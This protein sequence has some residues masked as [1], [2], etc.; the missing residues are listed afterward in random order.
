MTLVRW[1]V[2]LLILSACSSAFAQDHR[3]K[4]FVSGDNFVVASYARGDDQ[5]N[6][7][8]PPSLVLDNP[9]KH[10]IACLGP[11]DVFATRREE[12]NLPQCVTRTMK[13]VGLFYRP[14]AGFA[15]DDKI[16]F[17]VIFPTVKRS[18]EVELHVI[19]DDFLAKKRGTLGFVA[20]ANAKPQVA[21]QIPAC[22]EN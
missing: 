21:G 10:G 5:C 14:R 19:V 6:S 8:E 13:G 1:L 18:F 12:G 2:V 20:P 11:R 15:G 3:R 7:I 22:I 9:P 17:T 4:T 16:R